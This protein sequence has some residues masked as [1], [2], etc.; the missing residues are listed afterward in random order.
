M[1][2]TFFYISALLVA[3]VLVVTSCKKDKPNK[4]EDS[5]PVQASI[6]GGGEGSQTCENLI[7]TYVLTATA[8]GATSFVWRNGSVEIKGAT[9]STLTLQ[10]TDSMPNM[11]NI[12]VAG[13][14]ESGQGLF[15]SAR[16]V[17]FSAC[18]AP[19]K[20]TITGLDTI[21]CF[22][23]SI[24]LT[25]NASGASTYTWYKNDVKIEFESSPTLAVTDSGTYTVKAVN[26]QGEG[27]LSAP[28][29]VKKLEGED[30]AGL[31]SNLFRLEG[32][33]IVT[34]IATRSFWTS[35][36][37]I[38]DTAAG[39]KDTVVD[40]GNNTYATT[41]F[42]NRGIPMFYMEDPN[43]ANRFVFLNDYQLDDDDGDPVVQIV[44]GKMPDGKW[45][46][47]RGES[48]IDLIWSAEGT[49]FTFP[50]LEV[51]QDGGAKIDITEVGI[52]MVIKRPN[53]QISGALWSMVA[54]MEVSRERTST[55]TQAR[56]SQIQKP[57][58]KLPSTCKLVE[59]PEHMFPVDDLR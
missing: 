22:Q 17:V 57:K 39:W 31:D 8:E 43:E 45:T 7:P 40:Q 59:L 49:S 29:T 50:D 16:R 51:T 2:R 52:A 53:N 14:N 13:V 30:C 23:R 19:G 21:Y 42:A 41:N 47:I 44:V 35:L 46:V 15:S 58:V 32:T 5:V 25:A 26:L 11:V 6:S 1:K 38:P 48:D 27:E 18:A 36:G 24:T 28:K 12:T 34:G 20:A 9:T 4:N 54:R 55:A 37:S 3:L 56:K 33:W 10:K